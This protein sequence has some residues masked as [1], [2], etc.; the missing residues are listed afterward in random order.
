MYEIKL[1]IDS[2]TVTV[3]TIH[4]RLGN[5][6]GQTRLC[7]SVA[8]RRTRLYPPN[9]WGGSYRPGNP[10]ATRAHKRTNHLYGVLVA[11]LVS[12][13]ES[14]VKCIR[15]LIILSLLCVWEAAVDDPR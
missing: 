6:N 1:K 10:H 9:E 15:L 4:A 13:T 12:K 11:K 7:S 14:V 2:I 5:G 3:G 8:L